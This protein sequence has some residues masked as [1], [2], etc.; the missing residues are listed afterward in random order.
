VNFPGACGGYA[1]C[2]TEL[3][4]LNLGTPPQTVIPSDN[5]LLAWAELRRKDLN[6]LPETRFT[7]RVNH[8]INPQGHDIV[9]LATNQ[10]HC[11][12]KGAEHHSSTIYV[13][14]NLHTFLAV[15]RCSSHRVIS[16]VGEKCCEIRLSKYLKVPG[17]KHSEVE[18]RCPGWCGKEFRGSKK[19]CMMCKLDQDLVEEYSMPT[20]S[21]WNGPIVTAEDLLI[22]L[23]HDS[24]IRNLLQ[25]R[26]QLDIPHLRREGMKTDHEDLI[27][28][29]RNVLAPGFSQ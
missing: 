26:K 24:D 15:T 17:G 27:K 11:P 29:L 23:R 21:G 2:P 25:K 9:R 14:V 4:G 16:T 13:Q 20:P 18:Y 28:R 1:L 3:A 6:L 7:G 22:S 5:D 8:W 12:T 10:H 19:I